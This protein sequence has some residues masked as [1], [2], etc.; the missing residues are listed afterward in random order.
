MSLMT[1]GTSSV[2]FMVEL[3]RNAA[4]KVGNESTRS[5]EKGKM[6]TIVGDDRKEYEFKMRSKDDAKAFIR[7]VSAV[8]QMDQQT[9]SRIIQQNPHK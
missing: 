6:V 3:S 5:A 8:I 2:E 9:L 4:V 1:L 7:G